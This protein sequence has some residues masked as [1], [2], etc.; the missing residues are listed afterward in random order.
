MHTPISIDGIETRF[1]DIVQDVINVVFTKWATE[2][3]VGCPI[4]VF[5]TVNSF[6]QCG[7]PLNAEIALFTEHE[8]YTM[9]YDISRSV[10]LLNYNSLLIHL[11]VLVSSVTSPV[12]RMSSRLY[13]RDRER[14]KLFCRTLG[15]MLNN[16]YRGPL[17][18]IIS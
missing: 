5:K 18:L 13:Y 10:Q 16:P 1:I 12:R 4:Y 3:L 7:L 14:R 8:M 2:V 6:S 17:L 11:H 15:E 9:F